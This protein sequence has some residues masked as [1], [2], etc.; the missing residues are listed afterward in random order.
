MTTNV[1][2]SDWH[3]LTIQLSG[4]WLA[5]QVEQ[6]WNDY[7]LKWEPE[8]YGMSDRNVGNALMR[9]TVGRAGGVSKLHVPSEQIWL[10]GMV[11]HSLSTAI[12]SR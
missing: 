5:S 1:W 4:H 12:W 2:V 3:W 11:A 9:V 6:E 10:P 7:K 8:E